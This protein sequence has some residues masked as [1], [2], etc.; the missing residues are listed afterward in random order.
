M[1]ALLNL[2]LGGGSLSDTNLTLS[3]GGDVVLTGG[4]AT[5]SGA[6]LG[7]TITATPL[8]NNVT[9]NA[10]GSVILNGGTAQGAAIGYSVQAPTPPAGGTINEPNC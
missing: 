9:V 8:A 6:R 7:S 10:G 1:S 5:N 2:L 3:A 4:S